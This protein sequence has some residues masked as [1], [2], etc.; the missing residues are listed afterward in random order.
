[1]RDW[2]RAEPHR[3]ALIYGSAIPGYRAPAATILP[4]G[5]VINTFFAP[6]VGIDLR[7]DLPAREAATPRE[8]TG[9]LRAMGQTLGL[10]MAPATLL[11]GTGAFARVIGLLTLELN[12]HL[13]GGFEP[14]DDLFA[15]LLAQEAAQFAW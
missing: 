8:L 1:M 3:F 7:A 12:G 9:Q 2:A 5:R 15:T 13:V 10:A 11:A 6:L 14:A 4:A